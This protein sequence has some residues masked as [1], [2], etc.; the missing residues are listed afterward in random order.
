MSFAFI[1]AEKARF[2]IGRLC[3]TLGVSQSGYFAWRDRPACH[4]QRA[5]LVHLSHIRAAFA[6]SNGTS[7]S[8]RMHRDLVAVLN[9]GAHIVDV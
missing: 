4:R 5:D 9:R 8:P 3:R 1:E 6:L 2:P 7:G